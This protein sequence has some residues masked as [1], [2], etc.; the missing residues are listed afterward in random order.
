MP[1]IGHWPRY[2]IHIPPRFLSLIPAIQLED[3]Y[4]GVPPSHPL[5]N[6]S[7]QPLQQ[8]MDSMSNQ[9]QTGSSGPAS[10]STSNHLQASGSESGAGSMKPV[11]KDQQPDNKNHAS[12]SKSTVEVLLQQSKSESS[13]KLQQDANTT[14]SFNPGSSLGKRKARSPEPTTMDRSSH[15]NSDSNPD[16]KHDLT[17][18]PYLLRHPES[19]STSTDLLNVLLLPYRGAEYSHPVYIP[20]VIIII[21]IHFVHSCSYQSS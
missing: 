8:G 19:E 6:P 5:P 9:P 3:N 11:V 17:L 10:A 12:C 18:Y 4:K 21:I 7:V 1:Y 20:K 14:S 2:H 13:A 15:H 16:S